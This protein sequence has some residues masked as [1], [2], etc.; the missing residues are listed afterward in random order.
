M[1]QRVHLGA[2]L[3]LIHKNHDKS[4]SKEG[5]S[6]P[7]LTPTPIPTPSTGGRD[8]PAREREHKRDRRGDVGVGEVF[9][10]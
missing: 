5:V 6:E 4:A 9:T 10:D 2:V 3:F 7:T 1:P 8:R